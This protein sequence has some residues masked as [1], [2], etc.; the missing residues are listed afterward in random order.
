[1][2]YL[3]AHDLGTSGDKATLF[4]TDGQ[5]VGSV[6]A[7]YPSHYANGNWVEQNPEDWYGAVCR[8]T[9]TLTATV[10]PAEIL[11]VSFSGHMMGAVLLDG[12]GQLLRPAI[13][14][15]DQRA[16]EEQ[17]LLAQRVGDWRLYEITGNRNNPTNSIC[18]IM[19]AMS[20]DGLEGRLDKAVNCKDYLI[21]RLT[22]AIGTDYSDA[23]G[24]G[25]F[26]M[27]S[28]TW[29]REVLEAA[30]VPLSAMPALHASTDLAGRVTAQAAGETGL[31]ADTPVFC[32]CGDGTAAS[33]GTGISQV[34][35]GYLS[36][37]TSAW[38][39]YLD[40]AP[41]LDPKQRTFN[42]AGMEKGRV[43]PLGSMQAAGASYNWMRDRLCQMEAA[44]A[45]AEGGSVYDRINRQIGQVPPGA[46]G[47]VFLPYLMGER[48][49]WWDAKA[50]GAF[51]GL[52]QETTHSDML[53]AVM[54][55]VCMNLGLI[56][57]ALREKRAFSSLRIIGG[58]A[59]EPVWR[60]MLADVLNVRV[61]KLNL[62]EEGCSLG[63][64]MAAGIGAGVFSDASAISRF[65]HVDGVSEPNP[66]RVDQYAQL[67]LRF[68]DAYER[69]R[70][71]YHG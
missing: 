17:A 21:Y 66:E 47:V 25:A 53:R 62:L 71:F 44:E 29:S 18:K 54:E 63:A 48:S 61:E 36:L 2:Q 11:G 58:G 55:G 20:H 37:G 43:Y 51:L 22:G 38:I 9:K 65:L 4:T 8:A 40:D 39:A 52:N 16:T 64:A 45:K 19:W 14:W 49:P 13:I 26:D 27:N 10:D 31:L 30:G 42:L 67:T 5:L 50:K 56:L 32:G 59:K 6:V 1:M 7:A 3:L 57:G 34:G 70:G 41:L 60:Q 12:Q 68:Q 24:T 28:F 33:V 35:Q 69:L 23:G 15:A 46:N